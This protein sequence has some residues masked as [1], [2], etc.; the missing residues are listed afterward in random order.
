MLAARRALM[1]RQP[2]DAAHWPTFTQGFESTVCDLWHLQGS[3]AA[4]TP[5]GTRWSL[6]L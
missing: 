6:G 2:R 5:L 3:E 4:K 1:G